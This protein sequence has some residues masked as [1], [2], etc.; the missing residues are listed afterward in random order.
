MKNETLCDEYERF[1]VSS[2]FFQKKLCV[3]FFTY[4]NIIELKNQTYILYQ[5]LLK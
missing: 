5:Y 4:M 2:F 3:F 1:S